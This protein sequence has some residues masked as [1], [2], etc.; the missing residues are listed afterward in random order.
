MI[1]IRGPGKNAKFNKY[2]NKAKQLTNN[3]GEYLN[4]NN[5]LNKNTR[6]K[7]FNYTIFNNKKFVGFAIVKPTNKNLSIE[8]IVAKRSEP[9]KHY[10]A[11][12][13]NR[14]KQN[15]KEKFN[16]LTLV[17]VPKA[18]SFYTRQGFKPEGDYSFLYKF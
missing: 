15:S 2:I 10:G 18:R 5:F 17:S 6:N 1:V 14:I 7:N 9:R 11:L 13:M 16:K 8:L 3:S 4:F 12:L